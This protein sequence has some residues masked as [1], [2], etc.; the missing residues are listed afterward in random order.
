MGAVTVSAPVF[1]EA[2]RPDEAN[3]IRRTR[4]PCGRTTGSGERIERSGRPYA[5][6]AW[7]FNALFRKLSASGTTPGDLDAIYIDFEVYPHKPS[8]ARRLAICKYVIGNLV[9]HC[10]LNA[11]IT[12]PKREIVGKSPT[13]LRHSATVGAGCGHWMNPA[14]RAPHEA[15]N[16]LQLYDA[17]GSSWHNLWIGHQPAQTDRLRRAPRPEEKAE[18]PRRRGGWGGDDRTADA[19]A[20]MRKAGT[21]RSGLLRS[22]APAGRPEKTGAGEGIR[23]LDPNLGKVVLYP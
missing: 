1:P 8:Y 18:G 14:K 7:D 12:R 11:S 10:G 17:E 22:H 5:G 6:I 13:R 2:G 20:K 4:P 23:T 3:P 21:R 15:V 16:R 19:G 9:P